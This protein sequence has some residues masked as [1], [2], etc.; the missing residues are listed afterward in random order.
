MQT[1][2]VV[3]EFPSVQT[4]PFA[5]AGFEQMPV[6]WSHAPVTWHWSKAVQTTGLVPEHD[7]FTHAST[8]VQA[9]PSLHAVPFVAAGLEQVPLL[10]SQLPTAWH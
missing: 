5:A 3:H 6:L 4:V 7:P 9:F 1:S 2:F 10:G 8:C